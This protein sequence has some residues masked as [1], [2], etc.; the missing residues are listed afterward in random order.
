MVVGPELPFELKAIAVP[1][2]PSEARVN[3]EPR[4]HRG[5]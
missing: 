4:H 1:A 5:V 2:E 3:A